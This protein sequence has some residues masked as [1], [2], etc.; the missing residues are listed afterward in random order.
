MK[1]T[2]RELLSEILSL[3]EVQSNPELANFVQKEIALLNKK[4]ES[5]SQKS[6]SEHETIMSEIKTILTISGN[7][8]LMIAEMQAKSELLAGLSNQKISAMLKKLVDNGVCYK[9]K[10]KKTTKF[11]LVA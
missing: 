4:T 9:I 1:K 2:K 8:G 7:T 3:S 11:F 10:D 6:I 5:R